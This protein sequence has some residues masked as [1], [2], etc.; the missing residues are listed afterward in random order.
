[1]RINEGVAISSSKVLLVPYEKRHVK[2]YH[3]WMKSKEIQKVTASEPLTLKEEYLMQESW[4]HDHDKLTFIIC[5]PTSTPITKVIAGT[6]DANRLLLGDI[7]L[8][9]FAAQDYNNCCI[10]E[11]ELM[12][13]P[14]H[15][16]RQGYGRA[17]MLCFLYYI[18]THLDELMTEYC[19]SKNSKSKTMHLLY[20]SVKIHSENT[21]S[22]KLFESIGFRKVSDTANFFGELEFKLENCTES[23]TTT[24]LLEKFGI[25]AYNKLPCIEEVSTGGFSDEQKNHSTAIS[26]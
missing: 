10:G 25:E 14:L 7:N 6:H 16:R 5:T 17:A 4:R 19:G 1:M 2:T 8:F 23:E 11:L 18:Q 15:A 22:I 20:L 3:E 13:A 9:L 21:N 24:E 12:V 26:D